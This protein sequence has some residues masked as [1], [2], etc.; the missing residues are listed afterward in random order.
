MAAGLVP[1]AS[2]PE[3]TLDSLAAHDDLPDPSPPR[4]TG[5]WLRRA[6]QKIWRVVSVHMNN[7]HANRRRKDCR[8]TL[9]DLIGLALRDRADIMAGDFNQAGGYLE[10]CIYW[11]VKYYE[12]GNGLAPGTVQWALPEPECEIRTVISV[13]QLKAN[14]IACSIVTKETSVT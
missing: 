7:E 13:G 10:E 11:A 4:I 3:E 12:H 5:C 14:S 8:V 6:G 2:D 9:S 1:A